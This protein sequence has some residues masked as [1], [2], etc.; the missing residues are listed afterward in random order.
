MKTIITALMVMLAAPVCAGEIEVETYTASR[1]QDEDFYRVGDW[2]GIQLSYKFDNPL[3][4]FASYDV[5][6]IIPIQYSFD[7]EFF[8]LGVGM[9]K[10]VMDGLELFGQV[11]YYIIEN[12][13]GYR[14]GYTEGMH[15]YFNMRYPYDRTRFFGHEVRNDNTIGGSFGL[16][17]SH[18]L[19]EHWSVG[20]SGSVRWL[21]FTEHLYADRDDIYG[22]E[23]PRY[24]IAEGE[25]DFTSL[26]LGAS[27]KYTF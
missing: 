10:Q 23:Y 7:Y 12:S 8:G 20:L 26:N 19:T 3:Y 18:A 27:L 13:M 16:R 21:K 14:E 6:E 5:A 1:L 17:F 4:V 2:N 25:R 15:Y 22:I 24:W 11:G 9:R